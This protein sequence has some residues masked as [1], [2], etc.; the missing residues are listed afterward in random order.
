MLSSIAT[1]GFRGSQI[2]QK[3]SRLSI[4]KTFNTGTFSISAS[5]G[6]ASA[7]FTAT[8]MLRNTDAYCFFWGW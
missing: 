3:L 6:I 5:D 1:V 4:S 7:I 8:D 2:G